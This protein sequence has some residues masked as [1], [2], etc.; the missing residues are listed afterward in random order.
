[1]TPRPWPRLLR[2]VRAWPARHPVAA[3]TTLLLLFTFSTG[4]AVRMPVERLPT[5]GDATLQVEAELP[6]FDAATVEAALTM[7]L[8]A[9]L[10]ELPG[11]RAREA[12]S[13]AGRAV[14]TLLFVSPAQRERA[15]D[16]ARARVAHAYLDLPAGMEAPTVTRGAPTEPPA[17]VYAVTAAE[18]SEDIARWTRHIL[19]DPL[20]ELPEVGAITIEG[21]I[22]REIQIQPD[23]R[24]LAALGLG[25]HDLVQAVRSDEQ[26]P[27]TRR[28]TRHIMNIPS[29]VEAIASRAVRLPSG[30]PIALAE[31]A[32]VSVVARED[33]ARPRHG[34]APALRLAV[35]A[36]S[37]AQAP[38]VAERAHAHVAWLHANDVVP[39]NT[40]L[41]VLHDVA[42]A[43]KDWRRDIV[44]HAGLAIAVVLGVLF[45]AFGPRRSAVT[46]L[47]F[48]VWL[49][50]SIATLWSLGFALNPETAANTLLACLPFALMVALPPGTGGRLTILAAAGACWAAGVGL[51]SG[52][53]GWAAFAVVLSIGVLV[54]WLMA[55]WVGAN[56][57]ASRLA[58]AFA[59]KRPADW[60]LAAAMLVPL[61][62]LVVVAA[63]T[64][65]DIHT[66]QGTLRLRLLGGDMEQAQGLM[67]SMLPALHAIAHVDTVES[68]ARSGE[69]WR[70]H[71][72]PQRLAEAGIGAAEV[73]RA[74]AIATEGLV[75]GEIV[76]AEQEMP[77]RI[78]LPAGAAG[79]SFERLLLRGERDKR[80]AVYLRQVGLVERIEEPRERLRVN[81]KPAAEVTARWRGEEARAALEAFC[82][83]LDVPAGYRAEC[84]V[85]DSPF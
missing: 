84:M 12:R 79:E 36:R 13:R 25:L 70:L 55:Q 23:P 60:W 77:L 63:H 21:S 69:S 17:I 3:G 26:A 47:A 24:R 30:E 35:Y 51:G 4:F 68:S 7:P 18:L 28:S 16:M 29:G 80:P 6:G 39:A 83:E 54:R 65:S 72:D 11:V 49:P 43:T 64:V 74:F 44:A 56:A 5:A 73:G 45:V 50:L 41:H 62:V 67:Q 71:L 31:V 82:R 52:P 48:A 57:A 66:Q 78:R 38:Y 32:A 85:L 14:L 15:L 34:E 53:R 76:S 19:L 40:V 42:R 10:A 20:R 61:Y 9:A 59:L 27:R 33:A 2:G 8:D 37:S 46:A 1:M 22:Q 81:G 58:R 75:V